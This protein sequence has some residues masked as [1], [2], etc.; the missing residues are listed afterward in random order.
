MGTGLY[1]QRF[2]V[3]VLPPS[4]HRAALA[5]FSYRDHTTS[6][7]E[8]AKRVNERIEVSTSVGEL[9]VRVVRASHEDFNAVIRST[10]W[11]KLG[12]VAVRGEGQG[13]ARSSDDIANTVQLLSRET[14][15][16]AGKMAPQHLSST[17]WG[18]AKLAEKGAEVD[19]AVV[20]AVSEQAPRVADK[21]VPKRVS[22]TLYAIARLVERGV[23]VD[24]AA[25]RAVSKQAG[26]MAPQ[27]MSITLWGMRSSSPLR[28]RMCS[29]WLT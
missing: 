17:L 6:S 12:K 2:A 10:A 18:I 13:R 8:A 7:F 20:Q 9:L 29:R 14:L 24:L 11:S 21:M 26:K 27:H 28:G 3:G 5:S 19:A 15:R 1:A 16:A 25:V 22:R 4:S 23:E